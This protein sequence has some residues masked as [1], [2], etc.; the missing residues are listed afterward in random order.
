MR[1]RRSWRGTISW[2]KH[3]ALSTLLTSRR[4]TTKNITFCA[5]RTVVF[6]EKKAAA[7]G[8][9]LTYNGQA[10]A[11]CLGIR[12]VR[13]RFKHH[14]LGNKEQANLRQLHKYMCRS[15]YMKES[16]GYGGTQAISAPIT[17]IE[18]KQLKQYAQTN[19][20]D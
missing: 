5:P 11:A 4:I 6:A 19:M 12:G 20:V 1:E 8:V 17:S 3:T 10:H 16:F 18:N 9:L 13:V 15:K 2:P 7:R 14:A